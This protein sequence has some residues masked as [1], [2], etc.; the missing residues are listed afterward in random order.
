MAIK[1]AETLRP[2]LARPP[3]SSES[4]VGSAEKPVAAVSTPSMPTMVPSPDEPA[5][6]SVLTMPARM[7]SAPTLEV[8]EMDT[9]EMQ[10]E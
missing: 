1:L 4:P 10:K 5:V 9:S 3:I 7:P 6:L 2:S 8:E